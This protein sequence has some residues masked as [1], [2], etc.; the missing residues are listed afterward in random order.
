MYRDGLRPALQK[1]YPGARRF[2]VLEDN[3]PAGYKSCAGVQAKQDVKITPVD[4]PPR[5][6]D[7]NPLDY[8]IWAEINKRMRKQESAWP[9]TKKETRAQLVHRLRRTAMRLPAAYIEK[10]VGNLAARLQQLKEPGIRGGRFPE[11]GL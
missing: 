2:R 4:L 10:A 6:P 8:T 1:V 5:S 3:G 11:G 9:A 7:L